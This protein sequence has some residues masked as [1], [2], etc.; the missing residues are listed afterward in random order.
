MRIRMLGG[1]LVGSFQEYTLN[2]LQSQIPP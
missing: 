2:T 1:N